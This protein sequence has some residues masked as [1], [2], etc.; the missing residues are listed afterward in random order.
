MKT[1]IIKLLFCFGLFVFTNNVQAQFWKE[2]AAQI[3]ASAKQKASQKL[4][5]KIDNALDKG[6][7][8]TDSVVTGKKKILTKKKNK[9]GAE[10]MEE[11]NGAATTSEVEEKPDNEIVIKTNIKCGTGKMLVLAALQD[12]DGVAS[13]S[14]D[15]DSGKV[16]ITTSAKEAYDAASDVIRSNGFTADGKKPTNSKNNPCN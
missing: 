9:K 10:K 8:T 16:Y 15:T 7:E 6:V 12:T 1:I 14:I 4:D 5:N 11:D 2:K 3:K 13:V